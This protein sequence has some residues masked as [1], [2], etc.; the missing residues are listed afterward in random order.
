MTKIIN[1]F[2]IKIKNKKGTTLLET[3]IV[4]A[5]FAVLATI[6]LPYAPKQV[7]KATSAVA[8]QNA[9]MIAQAATLILIEYEIDGDDKATNISPMEL[10]IEA[11]GR[12]GLSSGNVTNAKL[13][14]IF[15]KDGKTVLGLQVKLIEFTTE[16]G[17]TK[18]TYQKKY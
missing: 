11:Q 14:K 9:N 6:A 1:L 13:S 17:S 15:D 8:Q 3:V 7:G 5:I 18:S 12:I 2:I 4:I 16:N 10:A